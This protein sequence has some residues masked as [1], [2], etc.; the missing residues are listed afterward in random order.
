MTITTSEWVVTA[1]SKTKKS[2]IRGSSCATGKC[3]L[4]VAVKPV[5]D[6]DHAVVAPHGLIGQAFDG[7]GIQ[8]H[9]TH[10]KTHH[11]CHRV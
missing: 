9:S 8:R 7:G 3:F 10:C 4:N 11:T 5:T 2:I 6:V 1:F